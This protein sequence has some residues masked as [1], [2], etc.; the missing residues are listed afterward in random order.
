MDGRP[1]RWT[2]FASRSGDAFGQER[3]PA[4]GHDHRPRRRRLYTLSTV[5]VERPKDWSA[6]ERAFRREARYRRCRHRTGKRRSARGRRRP[7]VHAR[8]S[9]RRA[10]SGRAW[11]NWSARRSSAGSSSS[12][13]RTK[14]WWWTAA[15]VLEEQEALA[16][17]KRF[18]EL[19]GATVVRGTVRSRHRFRRVRRHR[20]RRRLAARDRHGL[21]PRRQTVRLS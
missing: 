17:Q 20:R 7:G 12:T 3:R 13:R 2:C 6:L 4:H 5:K 15:S 8:L 9:Q 10:R 19:K 14:T 1:A 16:E 21:A 11:R 18:A